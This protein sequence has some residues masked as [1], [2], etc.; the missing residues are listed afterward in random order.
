[1][2]KRFIAF[3]R[4]SSREQ[5][6]EGWSLEIQ[7]DRLREYAARQ[8]GEIIQEYMVA[9]TASKAIERKTFKE[10]LAFARKQAHKL[11]GILVMKIDRAARNLFDY[12]D[13]ERLEAE[14]GV[15]LISVTQPTENDPAGRM[16][17]RTLAN[18]AAFYTEQQSVDVKAGH[19][20]RV[21]SGLFACKAPYGYRNIRADKRGLIE[22]HPEYA[23]RVKRVYELHA[24][25]NHTLDSLQEAL[26]QE[27][28]YYTAS[29][30][31]FP[32]SKLYSILTDRSYIG[33]VFYRGD[34]HP[35][36]HPKLVDRALFH[37]VQVL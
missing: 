14:H 6:E 2:T 4:V 7:R 35:G 21:E 27:G 17:R 33:E 19:E 30:P 31:R 9:E 32:R 24:F 18:M 34:W 22:L 37:R 11:D 13:L 1:M 28:T 15:K 8:Q 36:Q 25:H 23:P 5:K 20:R 12:V 29:T 16:M 3:A 26:H 10:M